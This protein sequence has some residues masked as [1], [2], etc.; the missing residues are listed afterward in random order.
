MESMHIRTPKVM[1]KNPK[2]DKN[3][4]IQGRKVL[5]RV[6]TYEETTNGSS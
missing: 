5:N 6:I 3:N 1:V 4:Y 2:N